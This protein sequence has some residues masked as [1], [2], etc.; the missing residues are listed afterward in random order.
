MAQVLECLPQ[1]CEA[2]SSNS[3]TAPKKEEKTFDLRHI[4]HFKKK[5]NIHLIQ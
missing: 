3:N 2:L 4:V 1:K 5:L